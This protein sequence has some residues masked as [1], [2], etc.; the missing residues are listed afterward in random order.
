MAETYKM[1]NGKFTD[2]FDLYLKEWNKIIKPLEKKGFDIIGFDP[3]IT[4]CDKKTG[5]G[6]FHIP[7]YAAKRL[8]NIKE[9]NDKS[10]TRM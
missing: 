10:E 7:L 2:R 1:P 6:V 3:S 4:M 8:L 5:G 9:S